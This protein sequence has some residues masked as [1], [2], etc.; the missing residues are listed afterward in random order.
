MNTILHCID[1]TGPGGAETVF[2]DLASRLSKHKYRSLVVIRGKGWVWEELR[3]RGME[4]ILL[5]AKGSFNWRYLGQLRKLIR[6]EGVN[7][8]QS[9]LLGSNVYCSLA[10]LLTGTPVVATFHGSVDIGDKERLKGVKFTLINAGADVVIAVSKQL[11]EDIIGRTPLNASKTRVIYNGIDTS[12]FR[13]PR[14]RNLRK[15]FGWPESDVV[16]GSLGNIRPAKGYDIL[17]RA[18]AVLQQSSH[19]Y[20][21]V[22]AGQGKGELY[23]E[24]LLLR[25]ELGLEERVQFL[26]F[27]DD[28]GDFLA[29]IDLFLSSSISEGLP[30]SAI[31]AMAANLPLIATRCGGYQELIRDRE[32]GWLV[33]VGDPAAIAAA[34]ETL[35]ADTRLQ[36]VL[37]ERARRYAVVTYD[38]KVML[39]AYEDIYD[40]LLAG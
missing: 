40:R 1:T 35:A 3:R 16:I 21:F 24:L 39:E 4:P 11:R 32:N 12:M 18:A 26:G 6:S 34:I 28:A 20:R 25:D 27:I 14:S 23:E 13:R 15:T 29:N 30:L 17:L 38:I 9:H 2:I 7:L 22:I 8:V 5:D 31:Q 19:S 37:G 36:A 10:G 33:E